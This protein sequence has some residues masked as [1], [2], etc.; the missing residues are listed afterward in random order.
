VIPP[1]AYTYYLDEMRNLS[2]QQK[3][4][5]RGKL[6]GAQTLLRGYKQRQEELSLALAH[7]KNSKVIE[8]LDSQIADALL[9]AER[10]EEL[11]K[12][13]KAD[14]AKSELPALS[15]EEFKSLIQNTAIKFKRATGVQKDMILRNLF[16]KLEMG[17]Q[18]ITGHLWKEPFAT[19]F[20]ACENRNGRGCEIRTHDLRVPNA[21]R[22]QAA[23]I[24]EAGRRQW[25]Y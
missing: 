10:Q 20:L 6:T 12:N 13:Y 19:L 8:S 2:G 16:L 5:L 4:A 21:A 11:I 1:E 17:E 14:L 9:G 7:T 18:T 23:L 25:P 24:P 22:Y 3:A 15:P